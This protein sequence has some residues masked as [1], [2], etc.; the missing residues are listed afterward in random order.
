MKTRRRFPLALAILLC[1]SA[2]VYPVQAQRQAKGDKQQAV[3]PAA[4]S[5]P[6]TG[7]GT[8]GRLSKWAGVEGTSTFT[9]GDSNIFEDKFGKVGIGTTAP[10][11]PLTVKGMIETTLGGYKFPDGTV[12][13]TAGLAAV[14]HDTTLKGNG[15]DAAPLG[16]ASPLALSGSVA[17]S[18]AVIKA[19]NT[20]TGAG[21]FGE[22]TAGS[23][24][25]AKARTGS[26]SMASAP[27]ASAWPARATI[28][29]VYSA[30][31]PVATATLSLG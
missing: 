28:L 23:G 7:S 4:A 13:T 19:S 27:T 9:L 1:L 20:G 10:T 31:A 3:P 6:V 15:T 29:L 18:E 12:Q 16:V 22:S 8:P 24:W 25:Q 21:L 30:Q 5:S 14:I 11:S 26:A 17:L 2:A